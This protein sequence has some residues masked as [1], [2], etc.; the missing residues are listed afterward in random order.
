MRLIGTV[1]FGTAEEW[2]A[3]TPGGKV[4]VRGACELRVPHRE[5]TFTVGVWPTHTS[6]QTCWGQ[7]SQ[8]ANCDDRRCM[9]CVLRVVHEDCRFDCPECSGVAGHE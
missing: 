3:A 1:E 5:H 9:D 7:Y 4:Q 2:L 6:G 8:C